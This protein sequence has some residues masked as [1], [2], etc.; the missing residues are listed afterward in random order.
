MAAGLMALAA[1]C[2]YSHAAEMRIC[3]VKLLVGNTLFVCIAEEF[4]QCGS[5]TVLA[6]HV[7]LLPLVAV[8]C[9]LFKPMSSDISSLKPLLDRIHC[10]IAIMQND[11]VVYANQFLAALNKDPSLEAIDAHLQA[12]PVLS[13]AIASFQAK[14]QPWAYISAAF[15]ENRLF[16]WDIC[17]INYHSSPA[18]ALICRESAASPGFKTR[19]IRSV[20]HNIKTPLNCIM[21]MSEELISAAEM[22]AGGGQKCEII[23]SYCHFMSFLVNDMVDYSDLASGRELILRKSRVNLKELLTKCYEMLTLFAEA[24]QLGLQISFDPNIQTYIFTDASRLT[25]L[26]L[27]L[28]SNA[29]KYTLHGSVKLIALQKS[30]KKVKI[31]VED[32]GIGIEPARLRNLVNSDKS[33]PTSGIGLYLV[34]ALAWELGHEE[35]QISSQ[36]GSGSAFSFTVIVKESPSGDMTPGLQPES[37]MLDVGGGDLHQLAPV[38]YTSKFMQRMERG[39][40]ILLVDDYPFNRMVVRTVLERERLRVDE[41][42]NGLIAIQMIQEKA[43]ISQHY[44]LIIM[45]IDMPVL[46]GIRTTERLRAMQLEDPSLALPPILGHSA[47]TS[48]ADIERFLAV[49]MQAFIPKPF[50][51][52]LAMSVIWRYMQPA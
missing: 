17:R 51:K 2:Y 14:S 47:F 5:S 22:P 45:D 25:Q 10:G 9:Y 37:P 31:I 50:I 28:L 19:I 43:G 13:K 34:N 11:H 23:R 21:H 6:A 36:P 15:L 3:M 44:R 35:L 8:L 41:A 33:L 16:D 18:M 40:D 29:I 52:D 20:T 46:D 49:G 7:E 42:E 32:S 38:F 4:L 1:Y 12:S 24:K 26:V 39:A 48:E 30:T 27:N